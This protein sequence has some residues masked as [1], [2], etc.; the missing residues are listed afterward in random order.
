MIVP[1]H[2]TSTKSHVKDPILWDL[3]RMQSYADL[4]A[5]QLTAEER[6]EAK[7]G[8]RKAK[9]GAHKGDRTPL[10]CIV[11]PD[12]SFRNGTRLATSFL[13]AGWWYHYRDP[14]GPRAH[15]AFR[16]P[17]RAPPEHTDD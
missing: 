3:S 13:H 14:K 11:V 17:F 1:M 2:W 8:F 4:A 15:E 9:A 7:E 6:A 16:V 5:A 12:A 10:R